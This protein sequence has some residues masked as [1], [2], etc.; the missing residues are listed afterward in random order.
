MAIS[1]DGSRIVSG[2]KDGAI[3]VWDVQTNKLAFKPLRS[4]T[5]WVVSIALSPDNT[6][7]ASSSEDSTICLW[8]AYTGC[9]VI[10]PLKLIDNSI[11]S[12]AF[13]PDGTRL[14]FGSTDHMIHTWDAHTLTAIAEPL[15]G[16][17]HRVYSVALSPDGSR[18]ASASWDHTIHLWDADTGALIGEPLQ[19]HQRAVGSVA[20]SSDGTRIISSSTDGTICIWDGRD[21][22]PIVRPFQRDDAVVHSVAFSPDC[23]RVVSGSMDGTVRIYDA[24]RGTLIGNPIKHH[25]LPVLSVAFLPCST[26]IASGS[27]DGTIC[28]WKA[29]GDVVLGNMTTREMFDCLLQHGC[30]DFTP[31]I[32]LTN[33][34][35]SAVAGGAFSDVWRALARDGK[36]IAIKCLRLHLIVKGDK[37]STKR[38]MRELYNW[39]KATHKNVQPLSGIIMFQ[40]HLGMVSPWMENGTLKQYIES[41]PSANRYQ[42]C[43]QVTEGVSYLHNI[44]MIHGDIKTANILV[45]NDSVVKINDFDYSLLANSSLIFSETKAGGGTVRWMAPEL[46]VPQDGEEDQRNEQTDVYALGM[47][48]LEIISGRMPFSYYKTEPMVIGALTKS[49]HPRRP[50]ELSEQNELADRMWAL[51]LTSWDYDPTNRPTAS[52]ISQSA[53]FISSPPLSISCP[54]INLGSAAALIQSVVYST[55]TPAGSTCAIMQSVGATVTAVIAVVAA[56]SAAAGAIVLGGIN[57]SSDEG[58]D[59]NDDEPEPSDGGGND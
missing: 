14:I 4:H 23:T 22:T 42:L 25:V 30:I 54:L 34:T 11:H 36:A 27:F 39:S 44:G 15:K 5:A 50:D 51:L 17:T 19:G 28:I 37:K 3:H 7:I 31:H 48:M 1:S 9:L 2:S 41:N 43:F 6:R 40:G 45:S 24:Q 58:D 35:S 8:D 57:N 46:L 53:V 20:F 10:D 16:H 38:M 47:T 33:Y 59:N 56:I 49:E 29:P 52:S 12:V 55:T 18:I 21:G 32:D 26:R 13:S